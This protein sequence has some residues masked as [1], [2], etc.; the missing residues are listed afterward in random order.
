M[1]PD[2]VTRKPESGVAFQHISRGPTRGNLIAGRSIEIPEST[3]IPENIE[4]PNSPIF[5]E[6]VTQ[7]RSESSKGVTV[8]FYC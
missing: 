1:A 8:N 6:C 2:H 3:E 5:Q 4:L 7:H